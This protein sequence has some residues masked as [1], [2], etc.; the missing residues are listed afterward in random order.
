MSDP[1]L[2]GWSSLRGRLASFD[3]AYAVALHLRGHRSVPFYV[4][5]TGNAIQPYRV[6]SFQPAWPEQWSALII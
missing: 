5:R 6:S 2:A 4:I 1:S 3:H